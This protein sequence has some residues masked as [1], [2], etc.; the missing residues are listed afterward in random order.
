[1]FNGG[2]DADT[3]TYAVR[4]GAVTVT[5]DGTAND[6]LVGEGDNVQGSVENIIG[7]FG[8]DTLTGNGSSNVLIGGPGNDSLFGKLGADTFLMRDGSADTADGGQGTDQAQIDGG[9]DTTTAV[10]TFIP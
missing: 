3:V 6:G 2:P 5:L 7:G 9:I 1:M 4:T 10:E 8:A